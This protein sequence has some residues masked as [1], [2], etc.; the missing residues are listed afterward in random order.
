MSSVNKFFL[1][2]MGTLCLFGGVSQTQA[3]EL[4][5]RDLRMQA[6]P[7]TASKWGYQPGQGP[8]QRAQEPV[9]TVSSSVATTPVQ[10]A[11][12]NEPA[13]EAQK[14]YPAPEVYPI[15]GQPEPL[16]APM[17]ASSDDWR[18]NYPRAEAS[19]PPKSSRGV[20]DARTTSAIDFGLQLSKYHYHERDLGVTIDGPQYG[21]SL[22]VTG[23]L[24]GYWFAKGDVKI[25]G[26]RLDYAGSG[27]IKRH[28]NYSVETK[29]AVGR[30]LVMGSFALSPYVGLS[31]RYL[32][33]DPTGISTTG[34]SGYKRR[35]HYLF[36]PIGLQP[37]VLLPN[38]DMISLTAEFNP[39]IRG[40][41]ESLFSSIR[42]DYPDL[43]NTQKAGYGLRGE[44]TYQTGLWSFGPYV[45]YW[46]INQSTTDCALGNG[47][48][49]CG[50]EPHN[51]TLDYG[52]QVKY[53]LYGE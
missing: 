11:I 33:N 4:T 52:M 49:V 38:D 12:S 41:Q 10:P 31:Y 7:M 15:V 50:Y 45:N 17:A 42:E 46:N 3:S 53:R 35:S 19:L 20:R 34:A 18:N 37:R 16:P 5:A 23:E 29:A 44:L 40:W 26:G 2:A 21:G 27:E 1:L 32:Y 47:W 30:D 43:K 25:V 13:L 39:L 24:G 14:V 28:P 22:S 51:H 48:I 8:R 9:Q 36:A 6:S